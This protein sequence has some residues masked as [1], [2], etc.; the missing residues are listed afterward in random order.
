M[1]GG[2]ENRVYFVV[3]RTIGGQCEPS[4]FVVGGYNNQSFSVLLCK[5]ECYANCF[6]KI[7]QFLDQIIGII[8]VA[9]PIYLA[10]FY[11]QEK[12]IFIFGKFFQGKF[13]GV[14]KK[15]APA[16][17]HFWHSVCCQ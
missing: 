5:I 3:I 11:H 13:C 8:V 14:W 1:A 17:A 16:F 2:R 6:V 7:Q 4:R 12:S 15:I 10:S 9:A